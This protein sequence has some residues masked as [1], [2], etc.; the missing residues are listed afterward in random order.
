MCSNCNSEIDEEI[1]CT[2]LVSGQKISIKPN[3]CPFCG[4][5]VD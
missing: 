3:F 2:D 5:E 4:Y 1:E